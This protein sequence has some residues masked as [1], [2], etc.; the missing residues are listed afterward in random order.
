[1]CGWSKGMVWVEWFGGVC[2]SWVMIGVGV[3]AG[4]LI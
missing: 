1:V 2:E 4:A 3:F